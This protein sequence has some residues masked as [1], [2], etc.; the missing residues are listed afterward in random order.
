MTR[1]KR[2]KK[3]SSEEDVLVDIGQTTDKVTHFFEENQ[4]TILTVIGGLILLVGG[5]YAYINFVKN[6]QVEKAVAEMYQAEMQFERD[7][8]SQAL[9][10]PGGGFPGFL[11]IIDEYGGTKTG[12]LAK[13][14]AGICYLNLGSFDEAIEYLSDFKTSDETLRVTKFGAL[15]DAYAEIGESENAEKHYKKAIEAGD[16]ESVSS[17]YIERLA[18]LHMKNGKKDE[19]KK[20]FENLKKKYPQS[21][22]AREADKYLALIEA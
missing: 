19:A 3:N 5:Y 17:I 10:N 14:Y 13:Y 9:T 6:P 15:A 20:L 12:K 7:S 4:N 16:I 1:H 11:D 8:F 21:T 22:A 2:N 18:L